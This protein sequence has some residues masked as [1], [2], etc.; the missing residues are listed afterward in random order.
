MWMMVRKRSSLQSGESAKNRITQRAEQIFNENARPEVYVGLFFNTATQPSKK[1][2]ERI[3]RSVA[4]TVSRNIPE[5]GD[6]VYVNYKIGSGSA[7]RSRF[8][9]NLSNNKFWD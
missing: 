5:L 2:E 7:V 1:D 9:F 3:S 8:D 4:E 6:Y